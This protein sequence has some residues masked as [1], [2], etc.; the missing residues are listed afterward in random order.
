MCIR[1]CVLTVKNL[2]FSNVYE[3]VACAF[4]EGLRITFSVY[5]NVT[6]SEVFKKFG[7]KLLALFL[8][9]VISAFPISEDVYSVRIISCV[10]HKV[11]CVCALFLYGVGHYVYAKGVVIHCVNVA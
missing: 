1:L 9:V 10:S 7:E 2:S 11:S 8:G 4:F 3:S 6:Y 5:Y